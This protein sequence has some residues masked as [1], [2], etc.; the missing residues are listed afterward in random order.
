MLYL[1]FLYVT[2][3]HLLSGVPPGTRTPI[4]GF[5]DRSTAIILERHDLEQDRRIEL[6]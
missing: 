3:Q 5:G 1:L 6:L 4:N 2:Q